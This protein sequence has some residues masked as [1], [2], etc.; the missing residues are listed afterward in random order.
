MGDL[1]ATEKVNSMARF[2]L[3]SRQIHDNC[4]TID[5][6]ELEHLRK[7]LRLK[8]GDRITVFDDTG[9]EHE[10]VIRSVAGAQGYIEIVKSY[11][12]Q[13]ESPLHLT[14]AV[15]LTKGDK[16]DFVVEKA[17]EL[18]VQNIIPFTSAHAVPKLDERK[19]AARTERWR[20][21]AL[22]ATKQCGRT[23]VP[24]VLPLCSFTE[25]MLQPAPAV[26][27]FFWEKELERSLR[28]VH[29]KYPDA[30]SMLLLIGP[31]GGFSVAE[32]ESAR[33]RGWESVQLGRRILRAETAALT[34]LSLVQ[35]LWGDLA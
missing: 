32:A 19:I 28:Q 10:A 30:K 2:F 13:R 25:L 17:T 14:L 20:K 34:A 3:P 31:E 23:D 15:A 33:A 29:E 5:G 8:S 21:I 18:G 4:G 22:S 6:P 9:W 26:K 7:V 24:A 11:Q 1:V 16:L 12:A 35:F 27:L